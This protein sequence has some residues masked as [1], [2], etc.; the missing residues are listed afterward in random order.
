M[1][2]TFTA[3]LITRTLERVTTSRARRIAILGLTPASIAVRGALS[4]V[5]L[6]EDLLG[7]F[8]PNTPAEAARVRPLSELAEL[9]PDLLVIGEDAGKTE[10]LL[11][12]R[13]EV[14][15]RL[16]PPQVVIAGSEHLAFADPMYTALDAPALVPSYA[17]GSPN[18][19]EHLFACL[20]AAA[21]AGLQGAI[22]EFGAFKG[23]TT[24]WL[25]RCVK[26]LGL[27]ASPVI[28]LDSWSGFPPR[29]SLL[30]MYEHPRCMFSDLDAVRAY[31]EPFGVELIA[32]DISDTYLQL[33]GRPLLLCFFDTDNYSPA[34]A[35]LDLCANQLLVGG[36]IVFDHV[37]T[38]PDFIDTLGE[39]IAAYEVLEPAGFLHL[40]DT[41][42]FTKIA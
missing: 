4:S 27:N 5:G 29:R 39:R 20:K 9:A 13:K 34:R 2:E 35:A 32:G 33:K 1:S 28:G 23:G 38:F 15:E 36:S 16:P 8:A 11:A 41:G 40:H 21:A 25:A 24:A 17:T 3:E 7:I 22:V 42:V 18:T 30:D 12:Y 26:A 14:G 37:A 19:R 6:D 31:T 10:L